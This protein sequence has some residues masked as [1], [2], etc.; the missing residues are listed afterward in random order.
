MAYISRIQNIAVTALSYAWSSVKDQ[1]RHALNSI[2]LTPIRKAGLKDLAKMQLSSQSGIPQKSA[3]V[4]EEMPLI[5]GGM[6]ELGQSNLLEVL[7]HVVNNFVLSHELA[8]VEQNLCP[9]VKYLDR[10][11]ETRWVKEYNQ[12]ICSGTETPSRELLADLRAVEISKILLSRDLESLKSMGGGFSGSLGVEFRHEMQELLPI[13]EEVALLTVVYLLEYQLIVHLDAEGG[14]EIL[15]K[16]PYPIKNTKDYFKYYLEAGYASADYFNQAHIDPGL[17]AL[18]VVEAMGVG[19]VRNRTP[20]RVN[21]LFDLRLAPFITGRLTK[22]KNKHCG[23][24]GDVMRS[25]LVPY[26]MDKFG[27]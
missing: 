8:H 13:A 24:K 5:L 11:L 3:W 18:F 1:K 15:Q 16:E 4:L 19:H 25:E 17:R 10:R 12:I 26:V 27:R 9:N 7:K 14:L 21:I 23:N 2:P 6:E 22:I 20:K